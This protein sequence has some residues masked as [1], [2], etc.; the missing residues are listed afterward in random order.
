MASQP[1]PVARTQGAAAPTAAADRG[2]AALADALARLSVGGR[3]AGPSFSYVPESFDQV[4]LP[5]GG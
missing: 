4:G 1:D 2:S 5:A 3:G